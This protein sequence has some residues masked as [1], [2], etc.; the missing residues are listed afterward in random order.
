MQPFEPSMVPL[1]AMVE[2]LVLSKL[3][4]ST[5]LNIV[6]NLVLLQAIISL[7]RSTIC[8]L[9]CTNACFD[10]IFGVKG[11][12][13][14]QLALLVKLGSS[15]TCTLLL[16]R[17]LSHC[18]AHIVSMGT[19]IIKKIKNAIYICFLYNSVWVFLFF[20]NFRKA[21]NPFSFLHFHV[22]PTLVPIFYFHRF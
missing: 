7:A 11:N 5:T 4:S 3:A 16:R 1:N 17:E 8:L 18:M 13:W 6:T 9:V 2:T 21:K 20:N 12:K 10:L 22:I 15:F 19:L 14:C